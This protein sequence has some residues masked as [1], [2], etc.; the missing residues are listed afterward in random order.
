MAVTKSSVVL[1]SVVLLLLL[2]FTGYQFR[3]A[4]KQKTEAARAALEQARLAAALKQS[5]QQNLELER[6]VR[7]AEQRNAELQQKLDSPVAESPVPAVAKPVVSASEARIRNA[8]RMAK[9]KPLLESGQPIKGAVMVLVDGKPVPRPVEFVMGR[10]TRID[11]ADDGTYVVTPTL[12]PDGSVKYAISLL[13]KDT[14]GG[15]E[16]VETLPA[17][18]QTPWDGFI[19]GTGGGKVVAFDPDKSGP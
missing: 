2:G 15:N 5:E 18:I 8:E 6:R 9:M 17:V 13:R 4:A 19:L 11:A 10:E 1:A 12:N 7:L 3:E 16:H 14:V